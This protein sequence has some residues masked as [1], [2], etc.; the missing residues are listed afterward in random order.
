MGAECEW[1]PGTHLHNCL[2][3]FAVIVQLCTWHPF[4]HIRHPWARQP[5]AG[6]DAPPAGEDARAA[7]RPGPAARKGQEPRHGSCS[8][9]EA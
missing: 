7:R 6:E 2:E 5:S 8:L 9:P 3:A 1:V 4:I